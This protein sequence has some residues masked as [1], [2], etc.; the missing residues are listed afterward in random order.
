MMLLLDFA[1]ACVDCT[2]GN[3]KK[4]KKKKKYGNRFNNNIDRVTESTSRSIIII[5]YSSAQFINSK[6]SRCQ[7]SNKRRHS[8]I[9]P[10]LRMGYHTIIRAAFVCLSVCLFV[11]LLL[12]GPL[13]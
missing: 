3:K 7:G 8:I 12:R 10:P 5:V 4:K 9:L 13:I 1:V 2:G 6:C 11:P